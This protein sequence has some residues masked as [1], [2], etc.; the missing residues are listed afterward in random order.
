MV[1]IIQL[2]PVINSADTYH[3]VPPEIQLLVRLGRL[4]S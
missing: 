3:D 1:F 4:F 2:I